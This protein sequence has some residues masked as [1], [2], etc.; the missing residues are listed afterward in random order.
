VNHSKYLNA[1]VF[2][3]VGSSVGAAKIGNVSVEFIF[4]HVS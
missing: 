3:F 4:L 1:E 2:K